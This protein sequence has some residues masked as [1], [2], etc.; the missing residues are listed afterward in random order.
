M[1]ERN[2]VTIQDVAHEANVSIATVSRVINRSS[3]VASE[4]RNRV[5][6]VI[7]DLDFVPSSTAKQLANTGSQRTDF[8]SKAQDPERSPALTFE[9]VWTDRERR[10]VVDAITQCEGDGPWVGFKAQIG[11]DLLFAVI[12][13]RG[14]DLAICTGGTL[15]EL[16]EQFPPNA[17]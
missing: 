13:L 16:I 10:K 12:K 3:N 17:R 1:A 9:G 5:L 11:S 6:D 4:T 7:E 8:G 2:D 14:A 15:R